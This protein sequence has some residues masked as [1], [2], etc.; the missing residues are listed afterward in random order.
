[1]ADGKV[2]I[3]TEVDSKGAEQ[4]V[5][6]LGAGLKKV[7]SVAGKSLKAVGAASIAAGTAIVALGKKSVNLYAD[8]EQLTGGVE[9]LFGKSGDRLMKYANEAYKTAGL[10]ANEYMETVTSFSASMIKS[11]GGDT[12]KA[13]DYSN[14]ALI[15]MSDNAN[16]MGS[17]MQDI[18]NAY[19]GFS[20]QNYTML[21]NLKLGYGGTQAE[22][23]RLLKDAE[24][25]TGQK[26]DISSFSDITQAIHA[27]QTEMGITGTTSKEAATTIQGS[28]GMMKASFENFLTG[29]ADP[30]QDFDMLLGNLIDSIVTFADNLIPRIQEMLPRL[31]EGIN[32]L[33]NGLAPRIPEIIQTIFPVIMEG[34]MALVNGLVAAMPTLV[35]VVAQALP[36]FMD[37]LMQAIPNL[38]S[39]GIEIVTTLCTTILSL[40][41][42]LLE[43]GIQLIVQLILGIAQQAPTL[44]D[45]IIDAIFGVQDA[46]LD[47]LP[48]ILDA[49]LQ[50]IIGLAEGLVKAIPKLVERIP[51]IIDKMIATLIKM[52]PMIIDTGIKLLTALVENMPAIISAIVKAI[53]QIINAIVDNIDTLVPLLVNAGVQLFIALVKNLPLIIATLIVAVNDIITAILGSLI[54][55]IPRLAQTGLKLL[56]SIGSKIGECCSWLGGKMKEIVNA[57]KDGILKKIKEVKEV[58]KNIIN[59]VWEGIKSMKDKITKNVKN[60]FGGIVDGVKD[61]LGIHSPSR[62]FRDVIGKMIGEGVIVGIK[63]KYAKAKKTASQLATLIYEAAK[64]KLDTY[65]KYNDMTLANEVSYWAKIVKATKKG[66]QGYKDAML[67]YKNAKNELDTQLKQAEQEYADKVSE[68]KTSLIK[69]IQSVT[70]AYD[71]AVQKRKESILGSMD[72]F[73]E[74]SSETDNTSETLLTNLQGQV[75]ALAEWDLMLDN[76]ANRGVNTKFVEEL[77][78]MGPSVLAD[79]KQINAMTD[80]QLN[81]YVELWNRKSQLA[82]GRAVE[83]L[84]GYRQECQAQIEVLIKEANSNL[85]QLEKDFN[86]TLKSLGVSTSDKSVSIGKSIVKGLKEGIQSQQSELDAFLNTFFGNITARAQNALSSITGAFNSAVNASANSSNSKL[87]NTIHNSSVVNNQTINV[88]QKVSTPDEIVRAVRLEER[89]A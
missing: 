82:E 26:Y 6:K 35:G 25:L 55:A 46:I 75:N 21:D 30:E 44:I 4:G 78:A 57:I 64:N 50:L 1:M 80:E 88:N 16:K 28:A 62:V 38:A 5:S 76:I 39:A 51:V 84:Q 72:L 48:L 32:Q 31:I 79:L 19:Q 34:A 56:K 87:N 89:Y 70:D 73:K 68:V 77:Q 49:G 63:A 83:E 71:N 2:T 43:I 29:M 41:P 37:G 9:T 69:D 10:S 40:L 61:K 53:P 45:T 66:T 42:Q 17:N 22:M 18:Q 33:I 13:A 3:E 60:F 47:N 81:Q 65:Q 54:D 14:Q 15:D 86:A 24:K 27:I 52:I 7:G 85:N 23:Q 74:F 8:Y 67:E 36:I 11:L 20:K 58:G 12:K 59:G